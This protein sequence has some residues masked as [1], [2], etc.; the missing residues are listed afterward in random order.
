MKRMVSSG[1]S[2]HGLT[3]KRMISI[4]FLDKI[5]KAYSYYEENDFKWIIITWAYYG[6]NDLMAFL[7]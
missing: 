5:I 2:T 7:Q 4:G 3:M 1:L 6:E